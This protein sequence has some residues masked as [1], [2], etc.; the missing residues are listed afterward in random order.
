MAAPSKSQFQEGLFISFSAGW[1]PSQFPVWVRVT[2][3]PLTFVA[4]DLADGRVLPRSHG[5]LQPHLQ[6]KNS[7]SH[8]VWL[9]PVHHRGAS[10]QASL[11]TLTRPAG[12]L[13]VSGSRSSNER[14][15][16]QKG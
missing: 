13:S 3:C 6:R 15:Q 9:L 16:R 5:L 1:T 2:S 4:L 10:L 12:L 8:P 14:L 11:T 7:T